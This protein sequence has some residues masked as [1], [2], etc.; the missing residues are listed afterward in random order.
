MLGK[1][2]AVEEKV[3]DYV[4]KLLISHL[5]KLQRESAVWQDSFFFN[6]CICTVN[7]P[8]YYSYVY[9]LISLIVACS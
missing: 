2:K 5:N 4:A 8:T 9:Y 3:F 1:N 7:V 6:T